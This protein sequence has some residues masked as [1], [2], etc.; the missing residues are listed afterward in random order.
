MEAQSKTCQNCKKEFTIETEDFNFYEKIKVP[1]PT[2]CPECRMIR[3]LSCANGWSLFFRN[4][5]KCGKR[6]L[7]MYSPSSKL[8]IYCQICWWADDW[9]GTEYAMEY[10]SGRPFFNQLKE[11]SEETPYQAL[12]TDYPTLKNCDYCN[13]LGYCKNC[14][15]AIWADNCENTFHSSL[16][17]ENKD[18]ADSLLIFSSELCYQSRWLHKSYRTFYSQDCDACNEVW[19]SRNCY[20]C[21]NCI[22]CVNL[23]GS[24]YKIFNEQYSKEEYFKKLQ[25]LS[26]DT[27]A[28]IEKLKKKA[29]EFWIKFPYRFYKGDNFNLNVSGEY[30]HKS[31]NSKNLYIVGVAQNC[32]Y[33]QLITYKPA[34]DCMDYSGWGHGAELIYE[35]GNVGV[36]V[37]GVK[38]SQYCWPEI[39]N[40]EYSFWSTSIKN[41]FGCI[42][43][44]RKHYSIL[45]KEY[46]KEEYEK[47]KTQIINSME[48]D[49][50]YGEFPL[51]VFSK[52]PYNNSNAN[53]FFPKTKEEALKI[54]YT[55]QDEIPQEGETTR[56]GKD[57]P[58]TIAEVDDSILNEVI[59]CSNCG[60]KYKIA[61]LEFDLLR[62]MKIPLPAQC[63]KCREDEQFSK[64]PK[65]KLY[66]RKCQKC[67]LAIQTSFPPEDPR[68]VYC[69]KD[70]QAEF[71]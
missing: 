15:L 22:G 47:L 39:L 23:R 59:A 56:E 26:L 21:T 53:K 63:L 62:K 51:S 33:C 35:S 11:L 29:E 69:V 44:K 24:S 65:P 34:N 60:R 20:S 36:N 52:F 4:C 30:I 50:T 57:L 6:T 37:T 19:F 28:G 25:E 71:L 9:D 61:Q 55:W 31:K 17:N 49:N 38:F 10:D 2:W 67:G 43:L 54:G 7:S 8:T 18:I 41:C 12:E 68:I 13:A 66:D 1:P 48:K 5:D 70:Y 45:N 27:R 46:S 40:V 14:L 16:I 58:Q 64:I 42:N 32:K 3:R